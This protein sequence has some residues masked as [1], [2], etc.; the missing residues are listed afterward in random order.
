MDVIITIF[1]PLIIGLLMIGYGVRLRMGHNKTWYMNPSMLAG[2]YVYAFI[3]L[4]IMSF[5]FGLAG[6]LR[7][8][9]AGDGILVVTRTLLIL[10]P[11]VL[12]AGLLVP[13]VWDYMKPDWLAWLQ[14][15]HGDIIE[16]LVED[17][18]E[19]G[20]DKWE[21]RV[22]TQKGLE[23]WVSEVRRKHGL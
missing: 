23:Q 18:R 3:P 4:G 2:S 14:R 17:A 16:L 19:M 5:L 1:A 9:F 8:I 13:L 7:L 12:V 20:L 11:L 21:Q 6:V 10:C 15:H 22:D